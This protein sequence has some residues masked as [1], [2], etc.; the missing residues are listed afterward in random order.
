MNT[1]RN[2]LS[3]EKNG[4]NWVNDYFVI[5]GNH[6]GAINIHFQFTQYNGDS[7]STSGS[8]TGKVSQIWTF[9]AK[10]LPTYSD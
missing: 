9:R 10:F 6:L 8:K 3:W 2:K 4:T 7:N 5:T 1:Q